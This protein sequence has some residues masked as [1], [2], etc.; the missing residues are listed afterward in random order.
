ML[1]DAKARYGPKIWLQLEKE[2]EQN[3]ILMKSQIPPELVKTD[4]SDIVPKE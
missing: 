3:E 4:L 1:G 2:S